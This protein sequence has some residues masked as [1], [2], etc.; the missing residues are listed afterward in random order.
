MGP[1]LSGVANASPCRLPV[2]LSLTLVGIIKR[3]YACLGE[4]G[5]S[6]RRALL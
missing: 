1:V 2:L 5:L 6:G 3:V 4:Y